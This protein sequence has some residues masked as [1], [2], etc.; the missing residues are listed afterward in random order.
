MSCLFQARCQ[1][2]ANTSA[3]RWA[4]LDSRAF[5]MLTTNRLVLGDTVENRGYVLESPH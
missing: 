3:A 5:G 4:E 1:R 2:S